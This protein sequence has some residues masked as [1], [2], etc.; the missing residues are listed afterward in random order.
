[1]TQFLTGTPACD[2]LRLTTF[3]RS[4]MESLVT[5]L[6]S[7]DV[8]PSDLTLRG[9]AGYMQTFPDGSVFWG[10]GEQK[11]M[12]HW[13]VQVSGAKS[14]KAMSQVIES[15]IEDYSCTRL[16]L[17]ITLPVPDWF[18]SRSFLDTL[19]TGTWVGRARKCTSVDNYGN[20]TVYIGSKTSDRF[21]RVY[22]KE[23][24]WLR[25]EVQYAKERADGCL[26]MMARHWH[27]GGRWVVGG[28]LNN[29][30][31]QLPEHPVVA[32]YDK[33]LDPYQP[34]TVTLQ[35][36]TSRRM[37]WFV[38]QCCPAIMTLL[39]DHDNGYRTREILQDMLDIT[40]DS[41]PDTV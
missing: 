15:G 29:E 7:C 38:K 13:I 4:S 36:P 35:K 41:L 14:N 6:T 5:L 19:R 16:D 31:S 24:E 26:K 17:Q 39:N 32:M 25:F 8:Q 28:I 40:L 37:K 3:N 18:K 34:V 23:V 22:V 30:V 12:H 21:I 20:D 1:M 27:R 33:S 2:Y 10:Q 9:Y 11:G